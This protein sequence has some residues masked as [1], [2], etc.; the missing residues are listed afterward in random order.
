VAERASQQ[1]T[2]GG[3]SILI[4]AV[5][6]AVAVVV[7]LYLVSRIDLAGVWSAIR[8][9]SLVAASAA[10]VVWMIGW[11]IVSYRLALLMQAQG[12]TMGTVEALEINLATLFYGLFLPG[13]NLTGIAVRFYR[14]SRAG[15]RYA[16]GLL[17]MACDRVAATAAIS[18]VGLACWALDPREKPASGLVVLVIGAASVAAT[19]APFAA[20]DQLRR[21][22]RFLQGRS[23]AWLHA[24][25][26]R[27]GRAFDAIA[28]LPVRTI[29][30]ILFLSCLAQL[31]GIA[32]FA[33]LAY[34]LGIPLSFGTLGWIR[35]VVLLVTALPI[36]VAGL[37]V[38]EG[39]LLI[40]LRPYGVSDADALAYSLL[41]FAVTIV[42]A[43]LAGGVFEA[44]R[45]LAPRPVR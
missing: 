11:V 45:W 29:G 36:S 44:V 6:V 5:R 14:L 4:V 28:H 22:G 35:S 34:A 26:R 8:G 10:F 43:G 16:A 40:L 18:L 12:V 21:L 15:G 17:A 33:I 25:L 30:L 37:G 20:A 42:A 2:G 23:V 32:A 38:R 13:G 24:G 41:I 9:T 1:A 31:P 7:S 27:V 39:V 3:R 19:I